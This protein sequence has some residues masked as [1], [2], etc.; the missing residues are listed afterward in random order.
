MTMVRASA[1]SGERRASARLASR[2]VAPKWI[3]WVAFVAAAPR[4]VG[5]RSTVRWN[6]RHCT[7]CAGCFEYAA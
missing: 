6:G 2:Q 5:D 4:A 1:G 7:G 3:Q